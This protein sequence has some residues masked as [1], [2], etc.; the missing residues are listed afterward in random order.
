M[1]S[2]AGL[3]WPM[4]HLDHLMCAKEIGPGQLYPSSGEILGLIEVIPDAVITVS[5]NGEIETLNRSAQAMLNLSERDIG[6]SLATVFRDPD[7]V[8]FLRSEKFNEPLEIRSPIRSAQTLE[9]WTLR[10]WYRTDSIIRA[11]YYSA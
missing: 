7:F 3:D 11:G 9:A 2:I 4:G 6:L 1:H 8:A 5:A 10:R